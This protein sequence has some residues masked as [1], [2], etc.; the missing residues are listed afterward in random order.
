SLIY[1]HAGIALSEAKS[2]MVYSRVTRRLR[3]TGLRS[4]GEYLAKLESDGREF[5]EFVNS[6]TTNLTSFFREEH[7]FP[8]LAS[9]IREQADLG[10]TVTMWSAACSTGEEAYSMAMTA[11]ETLGTDRPRIKILGT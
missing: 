11:I 2:D 7:H 8:L 1:T 4:F 10:E 6:L 5:E 9:L 3:A